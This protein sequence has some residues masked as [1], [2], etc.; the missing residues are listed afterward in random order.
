MERAASC[1]AFPASTKPT[2]FIIIIII[3]CKN[4]SDF[5]ISSFPCVHSFISISTPS[6]PPPPPPH[7]LL[8]PPPP[9][10]KV[11]W[12]VSDFHWK[13]RL[14]FQMVVTGIG[15]HG[16]GHRLTPTPLIDLHLRL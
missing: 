1:K 2:D 11:E 4:L 8:Q 7:G 3:A 13:P 15:G 14:V 10:V 12:E 6:T 9:N 5:N 16:H